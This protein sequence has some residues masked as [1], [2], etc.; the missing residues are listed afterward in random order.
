[1]SPRTG[2][3]AQVAIVVD[4]AA[5]LPADGTR[6]P[7]LLVVPMGLTVGGRTYLDG[8]DLGPTEFYRMLKKSTTPP[9]TSAPSPASFLEAFKEAS[10]EAG[11]ILCLTVASRFSSSFDSAQMAAREAKETLSGVEVSVL[12]SESA[13]GGEGLIALEAWRASVRGCAFEEVQAAAEKVM[14]R[15]RLVAFLD[16]LFYLWKGGRVSK[17]VQAGTSVLGI[18]PVFQLAQGEVSTVARPRTRNRAMR[19]LLELM[20]ESSQAGPVHATVMH[21]DA[22]Q[23]AEELRQRVES[24]FSCEELF[25]SEFT[26]VM[27]AHIGP[28]LVGIA[29]WIDDGTES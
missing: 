2:S 26:P 22:A 20:R 6:R 17:I 23:A 28:G 27:G 9:S 18:K 10:R 16:T 3:T 19:R 25:V 15:V 24:E 5:S 8:R 7:Q 12:D 29:Y 21:A 14:R 1:M 11:S 13:A 4:S